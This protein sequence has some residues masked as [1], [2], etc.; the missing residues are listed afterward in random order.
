MEPPLQ[1]LPK[2]ITQGGPPA[3]KITSGR[4]LLVVHQ[5]AKT[6]ET[7]FI[8]SVFASEI[9]RQPIATPLSLGANAKN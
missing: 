6:V 8:N 3:Q 9:V 5:A 4:Q 1:V 2:G 7:P